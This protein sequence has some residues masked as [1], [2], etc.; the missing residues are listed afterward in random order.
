MEKWNEISYNL[1]EKLNLSEDK[2]ELI[3]IQILGVLGW[4]KYTGDLEIQPVFKTY[5]RKS[6]RM[7]ILV[8]SETKNLF[9]IEVKKPSLPI[10]EDHIYQLKEYM[11]FLKL[12]FGLLFGEKIQVYYNGNKFG[13]KDFIL[14]D[15]IEYKSNNLK[16]LEF[17]EL[18]DKSKFNE[19]NLTNYIK[20]KLSEIQNNELTQKL[21]IELQT[22][23]ISVKI[24][25]LLK[26]ELTTKY[27]EQIIENVLKD[28][29]II[30][31][32]KS[33]QKI[34]QKPIKKEIKV[35]S[36]KNELTT[37]EYNANKK[38]IE[39]EKMERKLPKW[40][41]N[42]SFICSQ[43]LINYLELKSAEN[44]VTYEMLERKCNLKTFKSNFDQM[45]NFGIKIHGKVFEKTNS[46]ITI[47]EPVRENVEVEY[48][49]YKIK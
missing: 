9:V 46:I 11:R 43:I 19:T 49:K 20:N 39:I 10:I 24:K 35:F 44:S 45:K 2:F 13:N 18:L 31:K 27:S 34:I 22:N 30:I 33:Q 5:N 16:G 12:D 15:E 6:K 41:R 3:V 7:D 47:W 32:P 21:K 8:K 1:S 42:P 40:F 38:E 37:E 29:K 14:L 23:E 48:K 28:T 4:K 36:K 26:K 17:V 25:E